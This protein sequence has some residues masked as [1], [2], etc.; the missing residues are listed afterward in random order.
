MADIA[1]SAMASSQHVACSH[2]GIQNAERIGPEAELGQ[3]FKGY[4]WGPPSTD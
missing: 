2:L 4:S 3:A 1:W